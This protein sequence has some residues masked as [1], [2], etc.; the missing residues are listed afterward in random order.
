VRHPLRPALLLLALALGGCLGQGSQPSAPPANFSVAPGESQVVLNWTADPNLTYWIYYSQGSTT[1]LGNADHILFQVTPPY[2]LTGLTNNTQYAFAVTASD[3]G[4]QV[5]PFTP[6]VTAT[7]RPIG[8]LNTWT[9]GTPL[10]TGTNNLNAIAFGNNTYVAVGDGA[11]IWSAPFSYTSAGGVTGWTQ[12]T[13]PV[14]GVNLTG[15][16]YDG[17]RFVALG[18]DGTVLTSSD[19]TTWTA[20]TAIAGASGMHAIAY[21]VVNGTGIYVA[22]G[23]AGVIDYNGNAGVGGNW[24]PAS[25]G[26]AQNLYGVAFLNSQFVAVGAQGTVVTSPDGIT[27]TVQTSAAS[28]TTNALRAVAYGVVNGTG[29]YVAVGDAGTVLSSTDAVTWTAQSPPTPQNLN[30][31]AFGPDAQFV[32]VGAA[33]TT[34]YGTTGTSWASNNVGTNQDLYAIAPNAVYIAVGVADT[35]VSAK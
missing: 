28:A 24:T 2:D 19:G 12:Q 27:W 4:S 16:V 6:V 15:I 5:G 22:V 31:I 23:D 33:G 1:G 21:G 34:V 8:P 13:S 26:T 14:L 18:A 3:N 10:G 29:T 7:P 25:S 30:A 9:V 35:N 11:Q 20:A 17:T 32:A